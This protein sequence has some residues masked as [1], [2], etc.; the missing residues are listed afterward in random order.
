M[1]LCEGIVLI[2][3]FGDVGGGGVRGVECTRFAT[4][5]GGAPKSDLFSEMDLELELE[6][7]F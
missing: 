4:K 3:L 5:L 6:I 2:F 7:I 1:T